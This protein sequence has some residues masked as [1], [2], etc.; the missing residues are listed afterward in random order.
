MRLPYMIQ[1]VNTYMADLN[2]PVY[3][4][5]DT[6]QALEVLVTCGLV[7]GGSSVFNKRIDTDEVM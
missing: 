1:A 6:R 5:E 4:R 3:S 7:I 2:W